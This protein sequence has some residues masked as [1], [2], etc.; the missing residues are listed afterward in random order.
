MTDFDVSSNRQQALPQ[1]SLERSRPSQFNGGSPV[2]HQGNNRLLA[3]EA[4]LRQR[5]QAIQSSTEQSFALAQPANTP[6]YQPTRCNNRW[7]ELERELQLRRQSNILPQSDRPSIPTPPSPKPTIQRQVFDYNEPIHLQYHSDSFPRAAAI[8]D[9]APPKEVPAASNTWKVAN[10]LDEVKS[11]VL[12]PPPN[13]AKQQPPAVSDNEKQPIPKSPTL[14]ELATALLEIIN[15]QNRQP[16]E[17]SATSANPSPPN[18]KQMLIHATV[19]LNKWAEICL[20]LQN[21]I[22]EPLNWSNYLIHLIW[23]SNRQN[24]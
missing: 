4:E 13:I 18:P 20:I 3:L 5:K 17:F 15:E 12:A 22:W 2:Q 9:R 21:L 16:V 19:L 23:K 8:S 10:S 1:E 24:K 11:E 6:Q 14:E 7:L